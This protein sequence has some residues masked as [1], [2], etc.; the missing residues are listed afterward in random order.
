V[1]LSTNFFI[2]NILTVFIF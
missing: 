1:N 2:K